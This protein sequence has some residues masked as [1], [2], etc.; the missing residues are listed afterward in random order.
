MR[1]DVEKQWVDRDR[2]VIAGGRD[3]M[4]KFPSSME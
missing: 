3:G 4:T 2:C 1:K